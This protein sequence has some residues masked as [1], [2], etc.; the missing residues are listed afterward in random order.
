MIR[1]AHRDDIPALHRVRMAVLENRLT[2]TVLTDD[3]YIRALEFPG[4]TW[5]IESDG[6]VLAFAAANAATGNIWALFVDPDYEG[7]GYGRQLHD[8]MV[9]WLWAQGASR[10]WLTTVAGTRAH[11]FYTAAGWTL[12]GPAP[13]GEIR[14]ELSHP[15]NV[16]T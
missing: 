8:V 1:L 12:T 9:E 16:G 11:R 13:G 7:R 5:L 15:A 14:F 10:A 3:D 6:R 2:S 4:R